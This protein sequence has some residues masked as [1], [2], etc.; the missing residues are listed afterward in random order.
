MKKK[1]FKLTVLILL[2]IPTAVYANNQRTAVFISDLHIG[3]GA[4]NGKWVPTEDF[5][6]PNALKGFLTEISKEHG[7]AI[8]LVIVGDFL[9]MWQLPEDIKCNGPTAD[10]GCTV[11]EMEE[12]TRRILANHSTTIASLRSFSARGKNRVHVIPGNHDAALLLDEIWTLVFEKLGGDKDRI[13]L[14]ANGIWSTPDGRVVADHGHQIGS[15]VNRYDKWPVIT[16]KKN[17]ETHLFRVWGELFVQRLFNDEEA[18][19]SIIDNISPESAGVRYRMADRG[20]WK[21]VGDV[22]KFISFNLWETSLKQKGKFLG[23]EHDENNQPKWNLKIARDHGHK[24]IVSGLAPD[25]AF[26]KT[27]VDDNDQS[28]ALRKELDILVRSTPDTELQLLCDLAAIN[29]EEFGADSGVTC[30]DPT[31]GGSLSSMLI[32]RKWILRSHIKDI[33]KKNNKYKKMNIYIYGHTHKYEDKWNLKVNSMKSVS[34]LNTGAFQRL[35]SEDKLKDIAKQ[36]GISVERALRALDVNDLPPCYT[37]VV[38]NY[39][40]GYPKPELKMW[41]MPEEASTGHFVGLNDKRC[42]IIEK[43]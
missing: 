1:L 2:F 29:S 17:G 27:L 35:V 23:R 38:V 13:H 16:E 20:L 7:D 36:R 19:Y 33:I 30:D 11:D 12:L 43:D 32:P 18:E 31:L 25:D 26:R 34:V 28:E 24:L 8:D 22:A 37:S 6:W 9:E 4:L 10:L 39:K 15:D 41:Y 3:Q 14:V 40:N 21:S 42:Q 5:R